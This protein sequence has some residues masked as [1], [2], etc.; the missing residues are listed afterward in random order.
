MKKLENE[1]LTDNNLTALAKSIYEEAKAMGFTSADYVKLVNLILNFTMLKK[2]DNLTDNTQKEQEL[3]FV[4]DLP[5]ISENL[6]IRKYSKQTDREVL[7]KW[8]TDEKSKLF[9]LSR[10]SADDLDIEE[11]DNDK[12]NLFGLVT[13]RNGTPIGL[14]ALL[15]IDKKN[16]KAEMRKLIGN[17][18]YRGRGFAKEATRLWLNYCLRV[19]EL[20]KIYIN[21][22][23]A[24]IQ[25]IS[26]NRH[27]GF[28]IE[29]VLK[30]E[31]YIDGKHYDVFRMAYYK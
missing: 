12:N 1:V 10:T 23:E 16:K 25:N 26:L 2:E 27:L 9:L 17:S 4:S 5:I 8:L 29:G 21:T 3:L 30:N 18:Q 13:L 31:C 6:I 14:L 15:N 7:K 20:N 28:K 24:N 22:L 11:L 19:F